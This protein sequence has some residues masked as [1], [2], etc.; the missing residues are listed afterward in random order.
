MSTLNL[1]ENQSAYQIRAYKPGTIQVNELVYSQSLIVMPNKLIENWPPQSIDALSSKDLAP[2]IE[3]K[4][5]IV[6]LGTG[7]HHVLITAEIYG[8]LINHGIGVEVM[9]TGAACRTYNA[10]S[11]ENRNVAAALIIR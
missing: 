2:I 11:A 3:F 9:D 8:D 6:L 4:P 7:E 1:D 10:L 5:D